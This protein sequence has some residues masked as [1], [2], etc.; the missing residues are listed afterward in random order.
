MVL[1]FSFQKLYPFFGF[2]TRLNVLNEKK[3]M[4]TSTKIGIAIAS[5][6]DDSGVIT[7]GNGYWSLWTIESCNQVVV[8]VLLGNR[9]ANMKYKRQVVLEYIIYWKYWL[10]AILIRISLLMYTQYRTM[11]AR[12]P[13][14]V[15]TISN[16][17][18]VTKLCC[19]RACRH[20]DDA[21]LMRLHLMPGKSTLL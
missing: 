2:H 5:I 14:A 6:S 8:I 13:L 4:L 10:A 11:V 15:S 19:Y 17:K 16:P 9:Y 12:I 21:G 7:V 3:K 1:R 18:H 20:F